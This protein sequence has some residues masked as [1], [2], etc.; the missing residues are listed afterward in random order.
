MHG[1]AKYYILAVYSVTIPLVRINFI[2][3]IKTLVR[4]TNY[5]R[6]NVFP[7]I[8]LLSARCVRFTG[9][10]RSANQEI[11]HIVRI[12]KFIKSVRGK[13]AIDFTGRHLIFH[14]LE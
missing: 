5:I 9:D 4:V 11:P 2:S 1:Y 6:N 8:I 7:R 3:D 12:T 14:I 10:S 13:P